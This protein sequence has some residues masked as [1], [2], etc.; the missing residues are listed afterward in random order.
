MSIINRTDSPAAVAGRRKSRKRGKTRATKILLIKLEKRIRKY[1]S[2]RES[3]SSLERIQSNLIREMLILAQ[4][5]TINNRIAV[6]RARVIAFSII[7][8]SI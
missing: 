8:T 6:H 4:Y 5:E 7:S 1:L 2:D 3:F